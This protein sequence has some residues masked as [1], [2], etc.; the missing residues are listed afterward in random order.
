MEANK[1]GK[2][3]WFFRTLF[4]LF[5]MFLCLYAISANGY[6]KKTN[7][8]KTLF[9]EEQIKQF[10]HDVESGKEID[11][12]EYITYEE[13]DYSNSSSDLGEK[14]SSA[15]DFSANKSIEIFNSLFSFLFN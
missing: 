8:H 9:T 10:E 15:I 5:I 7:E 1:K 2:F 13:I 11:I 3:T 14:I 6:L 12:N 4:V